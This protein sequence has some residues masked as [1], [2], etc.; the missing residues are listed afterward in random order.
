MKILIADAMSGEAVDIL[1]SKGLSVDVK[2]D[3]KKEELAAIIGGYEALIVRSATK[4]T[5]DIIAKADKLKVIGRAGIGVDNVDVEAATEKGIVVMNTP[6]GNALAAAEHALALM[7]AVA[8]KVALADA[9]MKQGKWE[10]KLLMGIE[11]YDKTLG[12]IGIGNIGMI[13][14]E[15]AVALGMK[16]IAYDIFVAS[17]VAAA[18]GIELV[19]LDTLL[20]NSDFITVHLPM[21]KET[22]NL[23]EKNALAKTK[24][25]VIIL[26]TARGGIV[27][28]KD[29]YD[30]LMSGQVSGAGLDVFEQEPPPKD[31]PLVLSDKVVCTPHL[32]AST[33]EAQGKVAVDIADQIVD[34][35]LNGV[36]K[37]SVNAPP[38]SI[39]VQRQLASYIALSERLAT[40][41]SS[42][43]EFPVQ[44]I[45]IEYIGDISEMETTILTQA[46][47]RNILAH[48]L[49]GVN[50][51]N[52]PT[53]ARSRGIK[54]KEVRGKEHE[55]YTS[56]IGIKLTNGEMEKAAYGT[57]LGKK[58]PRLIR[59]DRIAVVADLAGNML[60]TY[61][62]D[63]PGVVGAIG[64]A[65]A[66][67]GINIG[68]MHV[69][70]RAEGGLAIA[71]LDVDGA[72]SDEVIT[73]LQGVPNVIEAK[74][75]TVS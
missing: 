67:K 2:T 11:V 38:V 53:V 69:G 43:T 10:K 51:V 16:V 60:L 50:Y 26:N 37:N 74:R 65:L 21:V 66:S 52:A 6:Q 19:D 1:K 61:H 4:V 63:K 59:L 57:L 48:H 36:I 3:L 39:E 30:A 64:V 54:I 56:L 47:I 35:A 24:K 49:E 70:R 18:K 17:E 62:Q 68:G 34:F 12:V 15:K 5:R 7:F 42:I 32:G 71:L 13:V 23:I 33:T 58:A 40:F 14:A 28:E 41:V 75:I 20:A 31:H 72:V 25:G 29:L 45:E 55:D 22:R 46:I 27:N 8:R 9:T 73:E 44:K